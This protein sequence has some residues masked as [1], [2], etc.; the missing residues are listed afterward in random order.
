MDVPTLILL[1][2]AG[3]ALRGLIDVYNRF[4][5]W[6]AARSAHRHTPDQQGESPPR[7]AEYF[8]PVADPIA[9]AVH[10][11]LV[12]APPCCSAPQARSTAPTQRSS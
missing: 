3:G 5:S 11:A 7:F 6:Q 2:A 8:D 10:S 1:G 9:A 12:P 4:Q